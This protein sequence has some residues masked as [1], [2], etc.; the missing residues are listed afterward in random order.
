MREGKAYQTTARSGVTAHGAVQL[1]PDSKDSHLN[2]A[3]PL[4]PLQT[5][6]HIAEG[7]AI[8]HT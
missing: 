2:D 1:C 6:R 3:P 8:L 5:P 7:S 4:T